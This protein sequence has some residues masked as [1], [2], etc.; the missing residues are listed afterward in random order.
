MEPASSTTSNEQALYRVL[1]DQG[2]LVGED[3]NLSQEAALEMFGLM[4]RSR[5]FDRKGVNLR[6]QGR[7]GE[8]YNCEGQESQVAA[9]LALGPDA[10]VFGTY[11]DSGVYL[12]RGLPAKTVA[13]F[14]RGLPRPDWDA[15][16]YR[17]AQIGLT[18]ATHLPHAVGYAHEAARQ[19][20]PTVTAAFFGD[21]ATSEGDF[22][23][24]LN[25]AGVWKTST[26][27]FCQNNQYAASVPLERQTAGIIG[28]RARGYGFPGIRV[29]GMDPLAVFE[30]TQQAVERSKAGEGPTLIESVVYRYGGHAAYE[31]TPTYRPAGELEQWRE[32]D[33]IDRFRVWLTEK[34]WYE[35]ELEQQIIDETTDELEAIAA[36][37]DESQELPSRAETILHTYSRP[38]QRLIKQLHRAQAATGEDL[39]Q[40]EPAELMIPKDEPD[41][42]GL[43]TEEMSL[44]EALN[45]ALHSVMEADDS[46]VL[47]GEDMTA[48]G[49]VFT[50]AKDLPEKFGPER[51]IDTPLCETGIVGAAVGMAL[52]GARP[53]PEMQFGGFIYPAFDQTVGHV[54]RMRWRNHGRVALPVVIRLAAFG[55][56]HG[57]E[58]HA[59]APEALFT[60]VPGLVV[61]VPASPVDG[62]GLLISALRGEDPVMFF[63]PIASYFGPKEPVPIEPYEIP[64]GR[65]RVRQEG[66]DVTVVAYGRSVRP[67][68]EAAERLGDGQSAEVIDLR[69]LKPWDE[70]T[71]LTS[72]SKTGRLVIAHEAWASSGVGAEIA[73]T[74]AEE[75]IY[76]LE[77]P[78][79][80]VT[81]ADALL[82]PQLA[83]DVC[84][85]TPEQI[86]SAIERTLQG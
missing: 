58:F 66:D 17:T 73:A 23:A 53:V 35:Q 2:Q 59:D 8:W 20:R 37:W 16:R 64:I 1:D 33:P 25:F 3:P 51:V 77:A 78:I 63:E 60:Q 27:F 36:A 49:G 76:D 55:G 86:Q 75:A 85:L 47:L 57:L 67:A 29:D 80:R 21:G 22:H 6:A 11:R 38:P 12:T 54:A 39:L 79:E 82:P 4:V 42:T 46:V 24:A 40:I 32:K 56:F 19:G 26:V 50:V 72:V 30:V 81:L 61:V 10:F 71:V 84:L 74:V 28:E 69:T 65:A 7:M 18:I 83:E 41:L 62:K 48:D 44:A 45:S 14:Y 68:L 9:A 34:G 15:A 70:E 31:P 52:A 43:E 5:A 13:A